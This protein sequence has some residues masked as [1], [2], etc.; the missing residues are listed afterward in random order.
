MSGSA[1]FADT[2]YGKYLGGVD[3]STDDFSAF[4]SNFS[5]PTKTFGDSSFQITAPTTNSTGA[6]TYSSSNTAVATVS[7]TTITI[8]GAGSSTITASQAAIAK[9][10]SE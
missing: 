1:T 2:E 9:L 8:V 5:I 4:V 7:G 6:F 10:W 3:T